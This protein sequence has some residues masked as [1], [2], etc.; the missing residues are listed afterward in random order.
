M[1]GD[2]GLEPLTSAMSTPFFRHEGLTNFSLEKLYKSYLQDRINTKGLTK[3]SIETIECH[4]KMLLK[5]YPDRF[6]SSDDM[7][8]FLGTKTPG[9]RRRAFETFRAFARWLNRR[10]IMREPWADIE[11]PRVP[12]SLPPVPTLEQVQSLFTYIDSCFESGVALR[13]KA[14]VAV[15]I[16]SGL[17]LSELASVTTS[18]IDW[19][20]HAR[21][22]ADF[23]SIIGHPRFQ[24][25]IEVL[26][27][28]ND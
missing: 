25:I 26:S 5:V 28:H 19:Q 4:F 12:K 13:N 6:P 11:K 27:S 3:T 18:D 14:I 20:E 23:D 17:R 21:S 10:R 16:E 22:Q 1:V 7:I 15:L 2:S 24:K 9:I 8:L